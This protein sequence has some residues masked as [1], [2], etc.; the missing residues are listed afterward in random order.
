M[1]LIGLS[2]A[3][4]ELEIILMFSLC[5]LE[6]R[7]EGGKASGPEKIPLILSF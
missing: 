5:F 4:S 1:S 6:Y 2:C 3:F 7:G